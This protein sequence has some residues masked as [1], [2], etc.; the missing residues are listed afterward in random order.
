MS[1]L[2]HWIPSLLV[3]AAILWKGG[4]L[5]NRLETLEKRLKA[6]EK[7]GLPVKFAILQERVEAKVANH[8]S[9]K[10]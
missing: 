7:E 2:F 9:V 3:I 1:E 4:Q 5:Q 6:I 8:N 10:N